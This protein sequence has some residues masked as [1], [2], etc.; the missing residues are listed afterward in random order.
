MI[1]LFE[2]REVE[3]TYKGLLTLFVSGDVDLDTIH[4]HFNP[5]RHRQIYFGADNLSIV[6]WDVVKRFVDTMV[7]LPI[8]VTVETSSPV[9]SMVVNWIHVVFKINGLTEKDINDVLETV[10]FHRLQ[11]K[12]DSVHCSYLMPADNIIWNLRSE[13]SNDKEL[14]WRNS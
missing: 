5:A 13:I 14:W 6:N 8:I 11:I 1:R 4:R 12:F 7:K 2:G 3:G 10:P 9:P